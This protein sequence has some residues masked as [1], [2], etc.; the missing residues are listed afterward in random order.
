MQRPSSLPALA[1]LKAEARQLRQHA[2][3][4]GA[5]VSHAAALERIAQYYGFRDWNTLRARASNLPELQ[6]GM[7]VSGRYLGQP[8][9]GHV[10]AIAACGSGGCRRIT[11]QFDRPVDVVT[12]D[13]FSNF[14]SRVSAIIGQDGTSPQ[15]ISGG[16]PQLVVTPLA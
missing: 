15:K 10:H 3:A 5:P 16:Q 12:F 1:Q 11:L 2:R 13:S 9:T 8:F 6:L 7:A 4:Q 14:R